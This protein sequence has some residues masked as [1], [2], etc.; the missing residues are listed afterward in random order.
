MVLL[1]YLTAVLFRFKTNIVVL[2]A[3]MPLREAH[4]SWLSAEVKLHENYVMLAVRLRQ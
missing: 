4:Q 1:L 2:N 3:Q